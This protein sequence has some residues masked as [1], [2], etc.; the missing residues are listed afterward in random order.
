VLSSKNDFQQSGFILD[1]NPNINGEYPF[2]IYAD[3]TTDGR[4]DGPYYC[5]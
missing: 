4:E 1:K 5:M 2:Q 3:M